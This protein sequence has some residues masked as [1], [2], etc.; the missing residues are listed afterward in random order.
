MLLL[1][2]LE[3]PPE[4]SLIILISHAPGKLLP[5]I[6]SRCR[7]LKVKP[8]PDAEVKTWLQGRTKASDQEIDQLT[9]LAHGAPGRALTLWEEGALEM[10]R[11]IERLLSQGALDQ[12]IM[13]KNGTS[14]KSASAKTDGAQKFNLF[15][16]CFL[17]QIHVRATT[18]ASL[19][20]AQLWSK[21]WSNWRE[22]WSILDAINQDRFDFFMSL[23]H[24]IK[25]MLR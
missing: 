14:F 3:E 24:E 13:L 25:A 16:T 4:K 19:Y 21:L 18:S 12:D 7:L 10:D 5:T 17:S 6:R 2:I 8:W 11:F 23:C 22:K 15:M 9:S 20:K 1:K